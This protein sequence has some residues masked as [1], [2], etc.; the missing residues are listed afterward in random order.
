MNLPGLLIEY[1]VIG[2]MS[3]IWIFPLV[4][5]SSVGIDSIGDLVVFVPLAYVIGLYIDF[6]G[7]LVFSKF[8][9]KS[10]SLKTLVRKY[11][12][13][14][15]EKLSETNI[16]LDGTGR[17]SNS[18]IW[19]HQNSK[20][21]LEEIKARSSRDRIARGAVV[22]LILFVLISRYA[23]M[24]GTVNDQMIWLNLGIFQS[25]ALVFLG[26][27]AWAYFEKSS[28]SFELRVGEAIFSDTNSK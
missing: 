4:S 23:T 6:A 14:K 26:I 2:A 9:I 22:N 21:L 27:F 24:T 8:P 5:G 3:V 10:L 1:L 11:V 12:H 13:S 20:S 18:T 19:L 17:N 15:F 28:Y 16:F 7:F 25:I